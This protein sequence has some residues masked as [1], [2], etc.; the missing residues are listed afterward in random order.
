MRELVYIS[1]AKRRCDPPE[2][3]SILEVARKNNARLGVTG[4]LLYEDGSFIQV[5]E[6]D[7]PVVQELFDKIARDPRHDRV[8]VLGDRAVDTRSFGEWTMGYVSLNPAILKQ[9]PK[10]HSLSSN[11]SLQDIKA[12]VVQMLDGFRDGRWRSYVRG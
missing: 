6:G 3:A 8:S 4:I 11:G 1:A 10:R 5:L 12:S 7:R 2:L 9:L